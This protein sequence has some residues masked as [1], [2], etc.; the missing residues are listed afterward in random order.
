M[1][2]TIQMIL[3]RRSIRKFNDKPIAKGTMEL[4][5]D[6][7]IHAPSGM[8]KDTWHFVGITNKALIDELIGIVAKALNNVNYTMYQPS[9]LIIPVNLADNGHGIEDNA[10]ALENIF[11]AANS[12]G[13]GSVWINQLRHC[14][15]DANLRK[16]F[17]KI[18][19]APTMNVYGI[20][21]LG[22]YDEKP[23]P[24]QRKGTYR[25]LE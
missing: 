23:L 25:L 2:E 1:N 14:N 18:G 13:I 8:G 20:A 5:M 17:D 10:C 22:Y 6:C 7:A 12:L 3:T 4:L 15:Q 11:I 9:A 19:I 16:F 24:K 21:A